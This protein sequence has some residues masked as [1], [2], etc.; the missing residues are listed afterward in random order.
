MTKETFDDGLLVGIGCHCGLQKDK[1]GNTFK[2]A[3]RPQLS[4]YE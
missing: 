4:E 2:K 1:L 3:R